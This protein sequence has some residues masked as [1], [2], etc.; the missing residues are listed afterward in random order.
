VLELAALI[1]FGLN[2]AA[3][4]RNRKRSYSAAEPLTPGTRVQDAVNARPQI[5]QRLRAVGVRMFDSAPFIAPSMTFGALALASGIQPAELIRALEGT[6]NTV[7]KVP[8]D[9]AGETMV[10]DADHASR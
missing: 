10:D 2:I 6:S 7:A 3:T 1:L 9:G 5:Q 4:A 8:P